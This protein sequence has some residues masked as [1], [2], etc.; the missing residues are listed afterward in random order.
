MKGSV[1]FI[2]RIL[3]IRSALRRPSA[4]GLILGRNCALLNDCSD[5]VIKTKQTLTEPD[6]DGTSVPAV[7]LVAELRSYACIRRMTIP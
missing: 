6:G 5:Q 3:A 4:A 7:T 1:P 2:K